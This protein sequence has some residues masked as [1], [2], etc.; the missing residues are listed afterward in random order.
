MREP[1]PGG[2]GRGGLGPPRA[3][4]SG[5]WTE[6]EGISPPRAAWD[7]EGRSVQL[8][9]RL[10]RLLGALSLGFFCMGVVR[11]SRS[12]W[13]VRLTLVHLSRFLSLP[14]RSIEMM[15]ILSLLCFLPGLVL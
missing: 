4:V 7:V 14:G 13:M 5:I 8:M 12:F 2:E 9:D 6:T 3:A 15:G 10:S 11:L 1:P